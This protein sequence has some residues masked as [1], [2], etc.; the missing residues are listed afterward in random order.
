MDLE[1]VIGVHAYAIGLIP[2]NEIRSLC[3]SIF[4]MPNAYEEWYT[5]QD[6]SDIERIPYEQPAVKAWCRRFIKET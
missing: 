6:L 1:R 5:G 2:I 3:G 4:D